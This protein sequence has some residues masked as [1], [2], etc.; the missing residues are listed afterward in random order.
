MQITQISDRV[1]QLARA[2]EQFKSVNDSRIQRLERKGNT[3]PLDNEQLRKLSEAIDEHKSRINQIEM[4][5]NRPNLIA[6]EYNEHL[7]S[8]EQKSFAQYLRKGTEIAN[9]QKS[10]SVGSE[11]DGGYLVTS[12][13]SKQI[14]TE[15]NDSS[16]IRKLASIETISSDAL[17]LL[18]DGDHAA[19]GWVGE[20]DV[21]EDT[22]T[23][24]IE[25]RKIQVHELY[26]QPKATQKLI[27]D[28]SIDIASW[29]AEKIAQS[30]ASME[31]KGFLFG[32][33]I[34]KP[35]GILSYTEGRSWG[36]IAV[37]TTKAGITAD[38]LFDLYYSMPA[39]Y[40][41][42]AGFMMHRNQ[43]QAIRMLK[44]PTSGQYLWSP[45]LAASTPDSLLGAPIYESADMPLPTAGN[46]SVLFADFK[47]AY[48]IVDRTGIRILRDPF[49]EKPFVKFYATKRVGGDVVNFNAVKL[50][51][52][53]K[54]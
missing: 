36:N 6:T 22:R 53:G 28:S 14:I 51:K 25:K 9:E 19:S 46:I 5:A 31:N 3:D 13:M 41:A 47:T 11:S 24:R 15:I 35:R 26:A 34:G 33:G 49:T 30:F 50:L 27:D 7:D 40:A 2:W 12:Q 17:D 21:R 8:S 52:L 23:S 1:E 43:L 48:K 44:D 18:G 37:H 54:A 38:D 32:N 42:K 16:V 39:Q 29:L 20:T 4:A 10:M 45:G